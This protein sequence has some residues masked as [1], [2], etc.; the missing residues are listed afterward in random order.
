MVQTQQPVIEQIV[1]KLRTLRPERLGEVED[2]I[3]FLS[4]REDERQL[5]RA[6][7]SASETALTAVWNNPDDAEYDQL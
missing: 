3:D 6:A 2:F 4:Q 5:T 1:H 7:M